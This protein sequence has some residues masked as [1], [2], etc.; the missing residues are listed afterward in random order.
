[1]SYNGNSISKPH[2]ASGPLGANLSWHPGPTSL[3]LCV[4]VSIR[5]REGELKLPPLKTLHSSINVKMIR[6]NK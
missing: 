5:R 1:M 2:G 3:Y 4:Y 6:L